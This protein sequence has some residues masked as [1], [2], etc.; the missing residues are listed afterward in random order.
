ML[1]FLMSTQ[2]AMN[3]PCILTLAA[4][5]FT[6]PGPIAGLLRCRPL[7]PASITRWVSSHKGPHEGPHLYSLMQSNTAA[8]CQV[9]LMGVSFMLTVFQS[10]QSL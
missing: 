9:K 3:V 1:S 5:N 10:F 7:A 2:V 4:R 8:L 6:L